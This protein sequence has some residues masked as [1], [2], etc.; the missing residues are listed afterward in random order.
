SS[1][2]DPSTTETYTLSLH[3]ALPIF[4]IT[5]DAQQSTCEFDW[6]AAKPQ[7]P[8]YRPD[9]SP[10][11]SEYQQALELIHKAKRPVILAGHGIIVSGAMKEVLTLAEKAGIPVAL[12][13]L[14][15][16]AFPA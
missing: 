15:L 4:D 9:L 3:D 13:L 10:E 2:T 11:E 14:G 1:S 12:T 8:G 16:G 6:E 7:L 5:K